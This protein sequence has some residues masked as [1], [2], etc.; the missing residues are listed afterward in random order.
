MTGT[1]TR[2]SR[3]ALL[4]YGLGKVIPGLLLFLA[5]PLWTR[6]FGTEQYGL[7]SIAWSVALFSSSLATG[8]IRQALLRHT[9]N[10]AATLSALPRWL[11]P[12][13]SLV[14]CAPVAVLVAFQLRHVDDAVPFVISA[15]AF[16]AINSA[17][18]VFQASAQRDG[19]SSTFTVAEVLRVGGAVLASLP[20]HA[21]GAVEGATAIL[22]AFCLSTLVAIATLQWRTPSRDDRLTPRLDR[23]GDNSTLAKFWNYG[24]PMAIWLAASSLLLYQD[25]VIIGAILGTEAAGEY[26]AV[27]D[28]IVRGFAMVSFPLTMMSHP[29]IMAA[30]NR[31]EPQQA[32]A[33]NRAFQRYLSII[34]ASIIVVGCLF[35]RTLMQIVLGIDITE[36]LL[37]PLLLVGAALWQ[38]GLMTHKELEMENKTRLMALLIVSVAVLSAVVN[39]MIVRWS[40]VLGPAAVFA[41]G[42]AA[43]AATTYSLGARVRNRSTH[44]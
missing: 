36:P 19:R 33:I 29:L 40:G 39:L 34:S 30:W 44:V 42:A 22:V 20:L 35:G 10:D 13:A 9:G 23:T 37:V 8:W 11:V 31:G 12:G 21:G 6:T 7:Y 27:A 43:Y 1:A 26:A 3:R 17:Y 2:V 14:S 5:V 24:W 32:V 18:T 25:R 16:A 28:V 15:L 38:L 4:S 41:A